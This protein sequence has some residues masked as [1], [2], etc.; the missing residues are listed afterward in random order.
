M[1]H[2]R[3]AADIVGGQAALARALEVKPPT[4]NQWVVG[5]RQVPAEKCPAIERVTGGQVRCEDLRP[6]VAWGVLRLAAT[7]A[8]TGA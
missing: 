4:V 6:D 3:A 7:E 1:N 5:T 8:K 2:V